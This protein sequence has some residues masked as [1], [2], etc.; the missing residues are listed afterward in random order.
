MLVGWRSRNQRVAVQ[1]YT[2]VVSRTDKGLFL[3]FCYVQA[4]PVPTFAFAEHV[5]KCRQ[6]CSDRQAMLNMMHQADTPGHASVA[7]LETHQSPC[8][9]CQTYTHTSQRIQVINLAQ[10]HIQ[11]ALWE[12]RCGATM[13][14]MQ[15]RNVYFNSATSSL[16]WKSHLRNICRQQNRV[17]ALWRFFSSSQPQ[18]I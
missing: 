9:F 1:A 6:P 5:Q 4:N 14:S 16:H 3:D 17:S 12:A 10:S 8:G 13:S 15:S 11:Q 7:C 18:N 2:K